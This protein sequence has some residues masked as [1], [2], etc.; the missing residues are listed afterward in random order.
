M[1]RTR[2]RSVVASATPP[3]VPKGAVIGNGRA[4]AAAAPANRERRQDAGER[5]E[6]EATMNTYRAEL[7]MAVQLV[8]GGLSLREASRA[9]GV[10]K[11]SIHRALAVPDVSHETDSGTPAAPQADAEDDL[12]YPDFLKRDPAAP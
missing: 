10:N 8:E 9:T 11:S 4:A 7:G 5:A 3:D 1:I 2:A 12:T 6:E